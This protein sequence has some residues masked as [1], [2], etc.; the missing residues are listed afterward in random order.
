M[1]SVCHFHPENLLTEKLV[2]DVYVN[3]PLALHETSFQQ[4]ANNLTEGTG[5]YFFWK[6][7]LQP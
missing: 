7:N 5:V 3:Y 4:A 1:Y 2:L 6:V